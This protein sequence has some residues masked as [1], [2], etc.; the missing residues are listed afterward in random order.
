MPLCTQYVSPNSPVP[1][2]CSVWAIFSQSLFPWK[3]ALQCSSHCSSS[4]WF[5]LSR[6]P[7]SLAHIVS[8]PFFYSYHTLL[9]RRWGLRVYPNY[10]Q[11]VRHHIPQNSSVQDKYGN[12]TTLNYCILQYLQ[13]CSQLCC[14]VFYNVKYVIFSYVFFMVYCDSN[15]KSSSFGSIS[16]FDSHVCC[17]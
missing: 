8:I 12:Y 9:P 7:S 2:L 10:W 1:P 3:M 17:Q 13:H 15:R 4:S 16:C 11:I 5:T 6:A 14:N